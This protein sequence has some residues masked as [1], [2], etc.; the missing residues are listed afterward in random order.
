VNG[1][2]YKGAI[3]TVPVPVAQVEPIAYSVTAKPNCCEEIIAETRTGTVR[4]G[5]YSFPT[6]MFSGPRSS[7]NNIAPFNALFK[8]G[9]ITTSNLTYTWDFGDGSPLEVTD[10]TTTRKT[11]T[12][13]APGTY[14]AKLSVKDKN[15][16]VRE[17]T[18]EVVVVPLPTR[19]L[20]IESTML[21]PYSR[22]PVMGYFK[23]DITDGN[24]RDTPIS[25]TWSVNEEVISERAAA[26]INFNEIG[27]HM[28][29]LEVKTKYGN[30]LNTTKAV[31]VTENKPPECTIM[32]SLFAVG[33]YQ[34]TAN[35]TDPDGKVVRYKWDLGGGATSSSQKA[36]L[37]VKQIGDYP[38]SL[39]ATDD[40]GDSITVNGVVSVMDMNA[41]PAGE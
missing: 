5:E 40:S 20:A 28:V 17:Y 16:E 15:D 38:V 13:T 18:T 25:S 39:T 12:Y 32:Q 35:C 21:N 29:K 2:E 26:L 33:K 7:E 31:E 8:T 9:V 3:I 14:T 19:N 27:T 24:R 6:I 4:I 11:H 30:L 34:L 10:K 36:Y 23:Y 1:T 37:G 22:R 41:A